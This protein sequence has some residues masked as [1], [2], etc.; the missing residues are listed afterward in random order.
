MSDW[1]NKETAA[2]LR[3]LGSDPVT[4]LSGAVAAHRLAENGPNELIDRGLKSPWRILWE[5]FTATMVLILIIAAVVS[6]LLGRPGEAIS[7]IAII[8]LFGLLGFA[9][10]YRAEQAM[11]ALKKMAVP[12][13]RGRRD[14][15]LNELPARDLVPGDVVVLEAGNSLPA[16]GRLIEC[17]GMRVQEAALTG[18]AVPVE[19][20]TRA[21][22]GSD[23]PLGDRRNM[24]Y[25]GT[26][27]TYGRGAMVVTATGMQVELGRIANALQSIAHAQTPLQKRLDQVGKML[28]IGGVLAAI[29]VMALGLLRGEDLREMFLTGVSVAVAVVPEGLPAVVTFTLALG[30]RRM[31]KRNPLIRR[32]PAVETLGA[33]TVIC[34]DKTGTLT[35]NRMTVVALDVAGHRLAL[36]GQADETL[37]PQPTSILLV[38]AAGALCNDSVLAP[39]AAA[40]AL[41]A[42]GDPTETALV[43]A[44]A[45]LGLSKSKLELANPRAAELP[46]DSERKRMTTIHHRH[47]GAD[48]LPDT[49]EPWPYLAFTKGAVDSLLTCANRVW[50]GEQAETMTAELR[51]RILTAN[52]GLAAQGMRVL[53]VAFRPVPSATVDESL[54]TNLIFAGLIGMIDPPRQEVKVAVQTCNAAGIRPVMITGDHPLTALAIARQLGIASDDRVITGQ[55]LALMS[56]SDLRRTVTGVSVFARVAPI[57]KLRIVQALQAQNQVVAM[58]GDG[59]NDAPALKRA[60]IGVAMGIT[61]TDVSKEASDMVLLDDNFATIVSAV[62]EG[63]TI[64]DNVRR[65]IKFSIAGNIGKIAVMLA[66]PLLGMPV[67]LLPLQLL[68]L[69]L[70]TDGILGLGLGV[71]PAERGTMRRPPRAPGE[72]IFAGGMGRHV[73]WMGA[74]IALIAGGIGWAYWSAGRE[75]WQTMVF[76][77]L[78]FCQVAQAL[79]VRSSH[80]SL[81]KLGLL[82]N[83]PLLALVVTVVLLQLGVLFLPFMDSFLHIEPLT[84]IDLAI[85][86]GLGSLVW[87]AVEVEK[88]LKTSAHIDK[89]I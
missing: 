29:L 9:Q 38:A 45:R 34:S 84:A 55:E 54:E 57:D 20:E 43:L 69:N 4:G 1:Y 7:I 88:R 74:L 14:G 80:D 73:L 75:T 26:M 52:N 22:T 6:A 44:A 33:V 83:K 2:V 17:A 87:V 15:R 42:V 35:E 67:A 62:E 41:N 61:G 46:F 72:S 12:Q 81:F 68:W 56:D 37:Q 59:V 77:T 47:A 60:D 18:E 28:A 64:Y 89:C 27:V 25:M 78:A 85:S 70:L 53:G 82:S 50:L 63:R 31:L 48:W 13:V 24:A 79:A 21:L 32:L 76:S 3:E 30:A 58:T 65:F 19:K 51:D 23:L 16:D 71:E 49:L 40:G 10:E 8:I 5:Q 36:D 66:A 39:D 86:A 11:A